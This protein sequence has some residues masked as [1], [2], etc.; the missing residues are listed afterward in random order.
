MALRISTESLA[1][2][3]AARPWTVIGVWALLLVG[4][5]V[6]I[7]ALLSGALTTEVHFTNNP[8][9]KRADTLLE[10]HLRGPAKTNEV[11]IV[12]STDKT[13]DDPGFKQFVQQLHSQISALGPGIIESGTDFY[14]SNDR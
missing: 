11:V 2:A 9:S 14:Q 7:G 1:R 4:A 10:D 8:E 6:M 3:S 13:V 12:R 5:F